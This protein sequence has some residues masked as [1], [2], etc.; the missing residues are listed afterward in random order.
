MAFF[1]YLF[2]EPVQSLKRINTSSDGKIE[3]EYI[4]NEDSN[5]MLNTRK[6][7]MRGAEDFKKVIDNLDEH[8]DIGEE[9]YSQYIEEQVLDYICNPSKQVVDAFK[10]IE[11]S[12]S[13]GGTFTRKVIEGQSFSIEDYRK[14]FWR[15][16]YVHSLDGFEK[17]KG[18]FVHSLLYSFG[19]LHLKQKLFDTLNLDK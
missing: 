3:F 2:T 4:E 19:G 12:A 11:H 7:I 13:F 6:K 17:T 9:Q 8:L 5:D 14:S 1:E 16:G 10:A 15:S 18:K